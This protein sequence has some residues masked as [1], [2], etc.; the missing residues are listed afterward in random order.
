MLNKNSWEIVK[1]FK[2]YYWFD[3]DIGRPKKF[4]VKYRS[5]MKNCDKGSNRVRKETGAGKKSNKIE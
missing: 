5:Q 4:D 1:L 3:P 2:P